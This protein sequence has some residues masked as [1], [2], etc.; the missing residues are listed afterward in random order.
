MYTG[1]LHANTDRANVAAF[2][3]FTH[4]H[5]SGASE[6]LERKKNVLICEPIVFLSIQY[7]PTLAHFTVM[8]SVATC[9]FSSP[10][11]APLCT[12]IFFLLKPPQQMFYSYSIMVMELK[13]ICK[14]SHRTFPHNCNAQFSSLSYIVWRAVITIKGHIHALV[15]AI[16]SWR[17]VCLARERVYFLVFT[18]LTLAETLAARDRMVF[19]AMSS[20]GDQQAKL[21]RSCCKYYSYYFCEINSWN[22]AL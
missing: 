4:S 3:L 19:F 9:Y 6:W 1:H 15:A 11:S 8:L 20:K 17:W 12:F 5:D 14:K 18:T 16:V 2:S 13:A 21:P 10:S 22:P 7:M